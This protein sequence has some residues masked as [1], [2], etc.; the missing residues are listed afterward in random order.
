MRKM[1]EDGS[2][3]CCDAENM[4]G[5]ETIGADDHRFFV[6]PKQVNIRQTIPNIEVGIGAEAEEAGGGSESGKW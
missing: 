4:I 3:F 2:Q 6:P 5:S 1:P